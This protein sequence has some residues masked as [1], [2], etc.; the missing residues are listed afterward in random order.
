M[1]L[2]PFPS[3]FRIKYTP[4]Y[5]FES[6]FNAFQ[7]TGMTAQSDLR[8]S[9]SI[10]PVQILPTRSHNRRRFLSVQMAVHP[11]GQMRKLDSPSVQMAGIL[12]QMA[13]I[14]AQSDG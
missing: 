5:K 12:I 14:S 4:V 10:Q 7:T 8:S 13:E 9:A 11:L 6:W 2:H 1:H 3:D